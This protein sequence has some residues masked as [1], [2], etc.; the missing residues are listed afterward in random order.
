[1]VMKKREN[2]KKKYQ[3]GPYKIIINTCLLLFFSTGAWFLSL[4][5]RT[6]SQWKKSAKLGFNLKHLLK[7]SFTVTLKPCSVASFDCPGSNFGTMT[8]RL[9]H[10]GFAHGETTGVGFMKS[11]IIFDVA[12]LLDQSNA[13]TEGSGRLPFLNSSRSS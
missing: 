11:R 6:G 8:R 3:P 5:A 1:M 12:G 10:L 9:M 7:S 4:R 13:F 2:I